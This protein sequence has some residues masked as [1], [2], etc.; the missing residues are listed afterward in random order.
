MGFANDDERHW[1]EPGLHGGRYYWPTD[2]KKQ[3]TLE[4]WVELF[5]AQGYAQVENR[6]IE[7]GYEKIAIFVHLEDMMPSHVA[8]SDGRVWK[9]KLGKGQDI[10]HASL[11]VL[12]GNQ[13][14]EYGIVERVLRRPLRQK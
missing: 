13:G 8:K 10:E 2:I 12:E 1:W 7:P 5:T 11:E 4:A 6:E 14:D 9:S 3:D